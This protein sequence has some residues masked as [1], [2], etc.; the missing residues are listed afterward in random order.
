MRTRAT[1]QCSALLALACAAVVSGCNGGSNL[2]IGAS[3][4]PSLTFTTTPTRTPTRT[5]TPNA[6]A[7]LA[8]IAVVRDDVA[9]RAPELGVPPTNWGKPADQASFDRSF[10]NADFT[11]NG[12]TAAG[13]TSADGG[14]TIP[15]LPPGRYTIELVKTVDGNLMP[16]T[17]PVV[18]GD[19]GQSRVVVEIGMG[20][21]RST[22]TFTRD[23]VELQEIRGP[24]GTWVVRDDT[25]LLE[26]GDP[27]RVLRDDD[28]DGRFDAGACAATPT[29]C[30][31]ET[32]VCADGSICQCVASCPFCDDCVAPGV[33]GVPNR[34]GVYRCAPD[35]TCSLPGDRCVDTCPE[36]FNG[37]IKVCVPD[38][39]PIDIAGITISGASQLVVGRQ[40]QLY[41]TAQ[42]TDGSVMD[43]TY[44]ADWQSSDESIA[45]VDSWG[46]ISTLRTGNVT[47]TAKLANDVSASFAF[48]VVDRPTLRQITIRNT[49]CFC[50]PIYAADAQIPG[51]LPP[52]YAAFP[53]RPDIL[54]FPSCTQT[55]VI[56]ATL[57]FSAFGEYADNSYEDITSTAIWNVD[58]SAVGSIDAG[59]F[60]AIAA[61]TATVQASLDGVTSNQEE[62]RVVTE[63]TVQSLSIYPGNYAYD[64]LAG[65]PLPDTGVASP[66]FDCGASVTV[67]RNDT[68]HIQATAHYDTGEWR[69]V[70]SQVAWRSSDTGVAT[71]DAG[72]LM[73]ALAAGS[74]TIDASLGSVVSN[75]INARVVD[76]ATVDNI[77]IYQEGTDRV[78][79][80]A[81]QRFFRATA[82]Y[83]IGIVRD[84][85]S[86]ATWASSDETVG[87]F[88]TPGV[89]TARSAGFVQV[90]A[91]RDG[92]R[93]QP[94]T[95]EV[96]ETSE[97]AYCDPT[98]INRAVWSD[99]FN[100]VLLESDCRSYT[101]PGLVTLRYTVTETRPHGGIFDPCL[102]L[103]VY[104]GDQRI[105]TIREE[106]CG[107]PFLPNAAPGHDEAA[108]KYQLRAF[109]DLKDDNGQA[110]PPGTYTVFGRFYL[111][112][113]PVVSVNIEVGG[114]NGTPR[115]TRPPVT[116]TPTPTAAA[117]RVAYLSIGSAVGKPGDQVSFDVSF[118]ALGIPVAALQ[119]DIVFH[120]LAV[121]ATAAGKPRCTVEPSI[122]KPATAFGFLPASCTQGSNCSG[123]RAVVLA[124]DNVDPIP[125]G[126][127]LYRCTATIPAATQPGTYALG[128]EG[129]TASDP[130]GGT[131]AVRC[132]PG[133]ISVGDVTTMP[134]AS[135]SD[136]SCYLGASDCSSSSFFPTAQDRCCAIAQRGGIAVALSWCPAGQRDAAGQC[137]A[138]TSPCDG[139][140]Q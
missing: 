70:S 109:W 44:L 102:D 134:P 114:G 78:V 41:A 112:Y 71:V 48:E 123:L 57:Q 95:L 15:A 32:R 67:L 28:G 115:P 80:K 27:S 1:I 73:T 16:I 18:I 30:G 6:V 45:T 103:Y 7:A 49:G 130:G 135:D 136:G 68:L 40:T 139:V 23:G 106:G 118:K 50:G 59:L 53:E 132:A 82:A 12:T 81:D 38:C 119:N 79:A 75:P 39:D 22:T 69:D 60:T 20:L 51:T 43:V 26:L 62:V 47:I 10:A 137:I 29:E 128:C 125:E 58:P 5:A 9:P 35:G 77:S 36:C 93:S 98:D 25:R 120:G 133:Q 104:D 11:I 122:N 88:D 2:V 96:F 37:G 87:G 86:E 92:K 54:P 124:I 14:F 24:F 34:K 94:L 33:C 55:L 127:S 56:G 97:L 42:L 84:I 89:F 72:G 138:C 63:A 52:C 85:T 129:A 117:D 101:Q 131:V 111:Y 64:A 126:T 17:V 46:R 4:T 110:V 21:V 83:D 90:W 65:G 3:P 76:H 108:V 99:D 140:M 31:T 19:A 105:R 91:E 107:E 116:A 61:G 13:T 74:T 113:D 66:C 100:R 121:D 8:G